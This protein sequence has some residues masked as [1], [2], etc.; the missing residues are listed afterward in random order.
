[1]RVISNFLS[2]IRHPAPLTSALRTLR[3]QLPRAA[4]LDTIGAVLPHDRR[5][6]LAAILTDG[7]VDTLRH[8]VERGLGANTLRAMTSDL[9]YLDSWCRFATGDELVWP[10]PVELVMK[11]IAHHLWDPAKRAE[12]TAHG[13]PDDVINALKGEGLLRSAGRHAV[14]T[15]RR[16]L[17]LWST[18]HRWRGLIGPFADPHIKTALKV[19]IRSTSN[20]VRRKSPKALTRDLIDKLVATCGQG[21]AADM[22]D[23]ALL[24]VGFASGGRRR[25]EIA[26]LDVAQLELQPTTRVDPGDAQSTA[27]SCIAI[28]LGRTKTE[29]G[30]RAVSVLV[31]GRPADALSQWLTSAKIASGPVFRSIDRWGRVG[32]EALTPE[33]VNLIIKRRCRL[34]GLDPAQYSAHGL[35]SGYLTEAARSGIPLLEAMQQSRHKTVQQA[36]IYYNEA[37]KATSHAARVLI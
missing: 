31:V 17:A 12:T 10:A 2:F 23:R 33:A 34:A 21:T 24:L 8:L 6:A 13:M 16:R 15:V 22:R 3:E 5:D 35:R 1:M 19:A 11:F 32:E 30:D 26:R 4:V 14:A 28:H 29:N 18:L 25:S 37:D 20:S 27:L 9:L 7:D 36:A